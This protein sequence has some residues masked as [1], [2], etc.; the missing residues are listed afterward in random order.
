MKF[1]EKK[2]F[3]SISSVVEDDDYEEDCFDDDDYEDLYFPDEE[4]T[5]EDEAESCFDPDYDY[6]EYDILE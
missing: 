4:D 5:R 3:G 6:G 2:N 1:N